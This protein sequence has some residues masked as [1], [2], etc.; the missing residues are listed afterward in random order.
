MDLITGSDEDVEA[1]SRSFLGNKLSGTMPNA[2]QISSQ[3][4][5]DVL[6]ADLLNKPLFILPG[7]W[8]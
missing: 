4:L 6:K 1:E 7:F 5:N 8:K 2:G 3:I